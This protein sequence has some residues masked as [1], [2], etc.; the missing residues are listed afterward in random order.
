MTQKK[1]IKI[2]LE[3]STINQ[4]LKFIDEE[5]NKYSLNDDDSK[6]LAETIIRLKRLFKSNEE[7]VAESKIK[8]GR[9]EKVIDM[10]LNLK[11]L[12]HT[13]KN[14]IIKELLK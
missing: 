3:N 9:S 14:K 2:D 1:L 12:T 4:C 13:D 11:S 8:V 6:I 7:N 5:F 10:V